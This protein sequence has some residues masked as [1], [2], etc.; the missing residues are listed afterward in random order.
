V[1][2]LEIGYRD[3]VVEVTK[4]MRDAWKIPAQTGAEA[5]GAQGEPGLA[6]AA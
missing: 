3:A 2:H 1:A 6:T 5:R 4:F